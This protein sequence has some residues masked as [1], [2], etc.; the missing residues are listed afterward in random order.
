MKIKKKVCLILGGSGLVGNEISQK[1]IKNNYYLIIADIKKPKKKNYDLFIKS[2]LINPKEI[3]KVC[4][5]L[6]QYKI[7]TIINSVRYAI[8]ANNLKKEVDTFENIMAYVK[9]NLSLFFYLKKKIIKN[10]TEFINIS[11][12]N[13]ISISQQPIIYHAAKSASNQIIRSLAVK[14][15]KFGSRFNNILLGVVDDKKNLDKKNFKKAISQS[16][17]LRKKVN[18][19]DVASFALYLSESNTSITGQDFIIDS[20]MSVQDQFSVVLQN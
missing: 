1:F 14:Y 10:K 11:S 4:K 8:S 13:S 15:G 16:L 3:K 9:I 2:N 20:G 7:D 6:N 5:I 19:K 17:P 18:L 12:T